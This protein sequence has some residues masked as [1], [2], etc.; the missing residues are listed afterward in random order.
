MYCDSSL[1]TPCRGR[2]IQA[3]VYNFSTSAHTPDGYRCAS[4]ILSWNIIWSLSV[5]DKYPVTQNLGLDKHDEV[6]KPMTFSDVVE[7]VKNLSTDEKVA[8]SLIVLLDC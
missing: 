4:W 2:S 5:G 8:L 6:L 3:A 1:T 7:I